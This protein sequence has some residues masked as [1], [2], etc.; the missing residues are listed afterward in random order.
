MQKT[1]QSIKIIYYIFIFYFHPL[2]LQ[3]IFFINF[4]NMNYIL[5]K[6][7]RKLS[8][9]FDSPYDHLNPHACKDET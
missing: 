4:R 9:N 3:H 1:I 5:L 8:I 6:L 2:C 7:L